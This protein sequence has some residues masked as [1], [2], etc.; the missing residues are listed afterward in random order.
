MTCALCDSELRM[1]HN[2]IPDT[3][4]VCDDCWNELRD[5]H[6]VTWVPIPEIH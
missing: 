3:E 1:A 4:A 6:E 2:P 5:E